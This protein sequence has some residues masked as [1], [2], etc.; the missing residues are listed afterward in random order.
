MTSS[1]F[2]FSFIIVFTQGDGDQTA[3]AIFVATD[4]SSPLHAREFSLVIDGTL[5]CKV[6]DLLTAAA[7]YLSA[8]YV[9]H[10]QYESSLQRTLEFCQI[11]LLEV[12][13]K[14]PTNKHVLT[15]MSRLNRKM[16]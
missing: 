16:P 7:C 2:L 12:K 10:L 8:F 1:L 9:F 15:L 3:P 14:C 13:D 4:E 11:A 6:G 5:V